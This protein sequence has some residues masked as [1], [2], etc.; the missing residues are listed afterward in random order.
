MIHIYTFCKVF[1]AT[2]PTHIHI[3]FERY[4]FYATYF[5]FEWNFYDSHIYA[6]ARHFHDS[7]YIYIYICCK[8]FFLLPTQHNTCFV[9]KVFFL[10]YLLSF[11]MAFSM[12]YVHIL[13][14][15][16]LYSWKA[17]PYLGAKYPPWR[18]PK[19]SASLKE[20]SPTCSHF[21]AFFHSRPKAWIPRPK[22]YFGSLF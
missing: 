2:Y 22:S 19:P 12:L 6:F 15:Y 8:V 10:C 5:H 14:T 18:S 21:Y 3:L 9:L 13:F 7:I 17:F 11:W 16:I 1:F 4:F 20:T